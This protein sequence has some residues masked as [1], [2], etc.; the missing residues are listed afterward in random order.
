VEADL[1]DDDFTSF[2]E[3][4]AP[5]EDPIEPA[6]EVSM[7][8]PQSDDEFLA[9]QHALEDE[10]ESTE[11]AELGMLEAVPETSEPAPRT[12][13]GEF[14]PF[15]FLEETPETQDEPSPMPEVNDAGNATTLPLATPPAS[16]PA[17]ESAPAQPAAPESPAIVKPKKRPHAAP[18]FPFTPQSSTAKS[19]APMA[20][21]AVSSSN[22]PDIKQPAESQTSATILEPF[23]GN[24]SPTEAR[25]EEAAPTELPNFALEE[26]K[27][28]S[29][30]DGQASEPKEEVKS[31]ADQDDDFSA[32]LKNLGK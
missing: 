25:S 30:A 7:D 28:E 16:E 4:D 14:S 3:T 6:A 2:L 5:L 27:S 8:E 17:T 11:A 10:L 20:S 32:F 12:G 21:D 13:E 18:R 29:P 31:D 26:A 1:S 24:G 15:A 19:P 22:E 23:S 9:P